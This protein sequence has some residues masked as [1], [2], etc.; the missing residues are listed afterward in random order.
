[1]RFNLYLIVD[2]VSGNFG[3][4]FLAPNDNAVLR[5]FKNIVNSQSVPSEI[6]RDTVIYC[7]GSFVP[8]DVI[9]AF[10]SL[11][12]ARVV[13]RGSSFVSAVEVN[14]DDET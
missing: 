11:P 14:I 4:C 1:M 5:D 10:E 2:S 12:D 8:G 7:F 9:P 3:S 6:L 13:C